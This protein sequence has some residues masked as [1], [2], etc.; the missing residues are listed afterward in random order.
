MGCENSGKGLMPPGYLLLA[1]ILMLAGDWLLAGPQLI[2]GS[3]RP[4]GS[5]PLVLGLGMNLAADRA[6]KQVQ[7]PVNPFATTST[8]ITWGIFGLSRNP[9]YLGSILILLGVWL[10]LGSLTPILFPLLFALIM[11]R[12]FISQEETKLSREFQDDWLSYTAKTRRW[13]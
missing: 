13:I 7:T 2:S 6:M 9:M 5:L 3:A 12:T 10:M 8:L 11:R 4:L 1:L